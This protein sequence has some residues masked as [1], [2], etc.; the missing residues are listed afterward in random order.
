MKLV[1]PNGKEIT[2]TVDDIP[3]CEAGIVNEGVTRNAD[4]EFVF[5]Y[6]GDTEVNWDGQKT[7]RDERGK[8]LFYDEDG[9]VWPED[10]LSLEG[11]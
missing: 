8:R 3:G 10:Q 1:A 7:C 5:D 4:G 2:G 9:N 11:A 6:S